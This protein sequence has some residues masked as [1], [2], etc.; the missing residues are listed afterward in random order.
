MALLAGASEQL[1][2]SLITKFDDSTKTTETPQTANTE[3]T[4]P[5]STGGSELT[6]I[7]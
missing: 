7:R 4:L 5:N 2:P 3:T 1:L 6:A